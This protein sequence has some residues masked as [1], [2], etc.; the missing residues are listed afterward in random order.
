MTTRFIKTNEQILHLNN[1]ED[2]IN[3][4]AHYTAHQNVPSTKDI[5]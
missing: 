4:Y 3:I 5:K 2:G 1:H